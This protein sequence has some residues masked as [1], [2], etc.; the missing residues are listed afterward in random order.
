MKI[1]GARAGAALA[2]SI[3][4]VLMA[5]ELTVYPL[6]R[7]FLQAWSGREFAKQHV[8]WWGGL[9]GELAVALALSLPAALAYRETVV[10]TTGRDSPPF[11]NRTRPTTMPWGAV[12][13]AEQRGQ[14]PEPRRSHCQRTN[15]APHSLRPFVIDDVRPRTRDEATYLGRPTRA[16]RSKPTSPSVANF[17]CQDFNPPFPLRERGSGEIF[18]SN[19]FGM[20]CGQL[21]SRRNSEKMTCS[22]RALYPAG[23]AAR[24]GSCRLQH[25][26][27]PQNLMRW[28]GSIS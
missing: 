28:R 8:L 27:Q 17:R 15:V 20:C 12:V 3:G 14:F 24:D 9:C 16:E 2:L 10:V 23:S 4:I 13:E 25:A 7:N 5:R 18:R 19:L 21:A 6:Q 11:D 22:A 1:G 26:R